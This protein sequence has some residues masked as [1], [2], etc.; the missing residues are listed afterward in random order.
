ILRT[1]VK[2]SRAEV[3]WDA[4]K[5]YLSNPN[6][7]AGVFLR[8]YRKHWN[9]K[10]FS[11]VGDH[12]SLHKKNIRIYGVA[13][14]VNQAKLAAN[15]LATFPQEIFSTHQAAV[16]MA[17][18]DLL[19]P[20]LN[21]LPPNIG[22]VNVTMGYPVRKTN[23]YSLF[24]TVFRL[25]VT[26]RRMRTAAGGMHTAFYFKDLVR[27][28][29]H[30][31]LAVMVEAETG[32]FSS[33]DFIRRIYESKKMFLTT[34]NLADFWGNADAFTSTF[35]LLLE[36]YAREPQKLLPALNSLVHRLDNAYRKQA[37]QQQVALENA[38]WF[39]DYESLLSVGIVI[40]KLLQYSQEQKMEPG[41]RLLYMLFQSMAR[42]SRLVLSGEPLAGL[43][44]MGMLETRNLDF[45]HLIILSANEDILPAA[46][47]NNSLIPFDVRAHF[48]MPVFR[49][50][51]AIYAYH[52]YRLLQRAENIHIIYNTQSQDMGSSE[53][54]RY[55]TQLQMEMPQWNP[56]IHISEQIIP[57]PPAGQEPPADIVIRK[58]PEIMA[59]LQKINAKGF[60][61]TTLNH[62]IK[63]SLYFYF[64]H[65]AGIEETVAPEE[66]I[67][68]NTLGT[69][70][71]EVLEQL[72]NDEKLPGKVLQVQHID[73]MLSGVE[74]AIAEKFAQVYKGGD[75]SS[76]KNLLLAKVATRY[77]K[78]FLLLEKKMIEELQSH[79]TVITYLR[80]E[81]EMTAQLQVRVM[82]TE[83]N[84]TIRGFADRID[85][86]GNTIRVIDYKT[87]K[88]DKKVELQVK[89]WEDII[90]NTKL[91]KSF[92]LMMY[93]LLYTRNYTNT[94]NLSP[95][96]IS[97]RSLAE[98]LMTL[99]Y[100]GG[101]G[102]IDNEA[103]V[104]FEQMLQQLFRKIFDPQQPFRRTQE[105]ENCIT[106]EFRVVCNR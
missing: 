58:T 105:E 85:K 77:V 39:T 80:A 103:I 33:E 31:A 16:V 95:G 61:P 53:K 6:H 18:E 49:E 104:R 14:N 42:E 62:F 59:A 36:G 81:E 101:D 12:F 10:E 97:F 56:N 22:K 5:Y 54:S 32:H 25:H 19:L 90:E 74:K 88:V 4:D 78:N 8:K 24:D 29:R 69:V 34:E 38:P 41:L 40:R 65:V 92:Q 72:Y 102:T 45:S 11:F 89:E 84:I 47:S 98:G 17:S 37:E 79:N 87:G 20:M 82:D 86:I 60:S 73:N 68:A 106:C 75:I 9:L 64:R 55:I 91:G 1:L 30:P 63:C 83:H 93:A 48:N 28:F 50:K 23:I 52:F 96:I 7:E 76:G 94:E 100:P 21:S 66:T 51:D 57:L 35:T 3:L 15:I 71:H 46:R 27:L 43:Q 70:I 99:T 13:K 2:Q 44:I 67:Q 26:T